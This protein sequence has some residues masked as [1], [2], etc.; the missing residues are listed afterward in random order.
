MNSKHEDFQ[1]LLKFLVLYQSRKS[2]AAF[3][4]VEKFKNGSVDLL[5]HRRGRL[6]KYVWHTSMVG[7]ASV[8]FLSSG[9]IGGNSM[10]ASTFPGVSAQDPQT[11]ETFDPTTTQSTIASLIDFK[12]DV[13]DKPRSEI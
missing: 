8:G 3:F 6:Q 13:S 10:V 7:L 4:H 12:T 11:V 5:M 2:K 9:A 1:S